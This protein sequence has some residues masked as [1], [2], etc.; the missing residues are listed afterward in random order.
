MPEDEVEF[1]KGITDAFGIYSAIPGWNDSALEAAKEL[2]ATHV[3]FPL[4]WPAIQ[5]FAPPAP[6]VWTATGGGIKENFNLPLL[7]AKAQELGLKV[8][9]VVTGAPSWTTRLKCHPG[10]TENIVYYPVGAGLGQYGDF[11]VR[12][13]Q[14]FGSTLEAIQVW[15]EPNLAN[16]PQ[17]I[18]DPADYSAILGNSIN[19]VRSAA[20]SKKV[21]SA[22]LYMP[23]NTPSTWQD[24]LDGYVNQCYDYGLALHPYQMRDWEG[25]HSNYE[26]KADNAVADTLELYDD[27]KDYLLGVHGI[28]TQ[29]LWVTETGAH[30]R[31]P[32]LQPGQKRVIRKLL[33]V[34]EGFDQRSSQCE[35][36]FAYRL[37]PFDHDD[38]DPNTTGNTLDGREG[39]AGTGKNFYK[40]S[41]LM[42][43]NAPKEAYTQLKAEWT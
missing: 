16:A 31:D 32:L 11:L 25:D 5:P 20:P 12:V 35:A 4:G 23:K 14:F 6:L 28:S 7:K 41:L 37:Y 19:K 10:W 21:L 17:A 40:A 9:P 13:V 22:G 36:A 1:Q 42:G 33:G 39:P 26:A 34:N 3:R 29:K 2:G 8:L 30:S 38:H 18:A 15:N 43:W 24:Y 27:L